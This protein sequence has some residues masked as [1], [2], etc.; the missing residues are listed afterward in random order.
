M[1]KRA[2]TLGTPGQLQLPF[3]PETITSRVAGEGRVKEAVR[4]ALK[5]T[6]ADCP[7]ERSQIAEE[8]SRLTGDPVS[9][10]VLNMWVAESKSDRRFPLEYV[11]ALILITND[12]SILQV[13]LRGTGFRIIDADES[14]LLDL[15][16]VTYDEMK[17]KKHKRAILG[18]LGL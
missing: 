8:L 1:S 10:H 2:R 7:L 11:A 4:E 5:K 3:G 6:L 17:R 14:R 15:G 13:I 12:T 18:G 16:M 9:E